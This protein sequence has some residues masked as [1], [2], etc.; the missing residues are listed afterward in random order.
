M[1]EQNTQE[2]K[3]TEND[4]FHIAQFIEISLEKGMPIEQVQRIIPIH[5]NLIGLLT[6]LENNRKAKTEEANA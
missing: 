4:L 2:Y 5:S 6:T 1:T 3:L